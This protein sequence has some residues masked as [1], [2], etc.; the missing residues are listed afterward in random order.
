MPERMALQ[1]PTSKLGL[2]LARWVGILVAIATGVAVGLGIYP[3]AKESPGTLN[4]LVPFIVAPVLAFG[5]GAAWHFVLGLAAHASDSPK[6]G[7]TAALGFAL[8]IVGCGTS[9]WFLC[10]ILGGATALQSY[11]HEYLQKLK[12]EKERVTRNAAS[13][14]ALV[15]AIGSGAVAIN[16]IAKSEAASGVVSGKTGKSVVFRALK[17]TADSLATKETKLERLAREREDHLSNAQ[18]FLIDAT[19]AIGTRNATLFRESSEHAAN[20][21]RAADKINLAIEVTGLAIGNLLE[22]HS[23]ALVK[24]TFGDIANVAR[25]VS[26]SHLEVSVP[27]YLPISPKEAVV[28]QPPAL[29]WIAAVLIEALPLI[30]LGVMLVL[31]REPHDDDT[32]HRDGGQ[33]LP[34]PIND[35]RPRPPLMAVE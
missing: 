10:T 12:D 14:R 8:F 18:R 30:M 7:L 35:Q 13:E 31:W 6:K 29:A 19:R 11:Q 9:A 26:E 28:A 33:T 23:R 16:T 34:T 4:V 25:L 27:D 2:P 20:E 1:R 3:D 21:V 32:E 5:L 24:G 17:D 22:E 15:G